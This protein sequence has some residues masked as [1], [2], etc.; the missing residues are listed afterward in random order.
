M[1]LV[2]INKCIDPIFLQKHQS[3]FFREGALVFR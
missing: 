3:T 1:I 2:S